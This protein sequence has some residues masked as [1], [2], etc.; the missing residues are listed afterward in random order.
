MR[1]PK[2]RRFIGRKIENATRKLLSESS[3]TEQ[4]PF[5]IFVV[6]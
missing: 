6:R 4:P 2:E 1:Q 3:V 5:D